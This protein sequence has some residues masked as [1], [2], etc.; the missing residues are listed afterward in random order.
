MTID[1]QQRVGTPVAFG[2]LQQQGIQ[3]PVREISIKFIT[4]N[5]LIRKISAIKKAWL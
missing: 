1:L 5:F 3:H 4:I 2:Q